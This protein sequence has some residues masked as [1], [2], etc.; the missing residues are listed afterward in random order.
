MTSLN[1]SLFGGL[2]PRMG[3]QKL[4]SA[5]AQIA[6][7]T[8]ITSGDLHGIRQPVLLK[9]LGSLGFTAQRVF[10]VLTD[11][12]Y[13]YLPFPY[14]ETHFLRAPLTVDEADRYYWTQPG[15]RP[16]YASADQIEAGDTDGYYLGVPAPTNAPTV[17]VAAG[18]TA[19]EVT[20]AYI[21]TFVSDFG[22]ESGPSEATV[23]S[24]EDDA[25]WVVSGLETSV[26]DSDQRDITRKR[27]Y[28]TVTGLSGDADYHF[29]G[30][31]ALSED[32]FYD[33]APTDE[34][35]LNDLCPSL[36]WGEP[37]EDLQGIVSHP[38]GALVGFSGKDLWFCEPYR[39]HA[40]PVGYV[41]S[42]KSNIVGLGIVG[43]SVIVATDEYPYTVT[44]IHPS[45]MS[46][47]QSKKAEPCLTINSIVSTDSGVFFASP[48]GLI[49]A[50]NNTFTNLT[51][52]L[53]TRRD[54]ASFNPKTID[55]ASY[56]NGYIAFT[57]ETDGF[58]F[59]PM[60]PLGVLFRL[61]DYWSVG[62]IQ[63]DVVPGYTH[64]V[65]NNRVYEFDPD[66]GLIVTYTWRSKEFNTTKPVNF[67]AYRIEWKSDDSISIER[68][69][70]YQEYNAARFAAGPL[71]T[72][73]Q[74]VLGGVKTYGLSVPAADPI[75]EWR[76]PLGGP[77]LY[78]IGLI[79]SIIKTV[80]LRVW[81]D[82]ALVYDQVVPTTLPMRLPAGFKADRWVFE[83]TG[84]ARVVNLK[85]A[86]T[87]T[88]LQ[89]V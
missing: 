2:A 43:T 12:G 76:Q 13:V 68:L 33:G 20:R 17:E 15:E 89:N 57:S 70:D 77:V 47:I 69:A 81:A 21:Y 34:I 31:I 80:T 73:A 72:L 8:Q 42:M 86:E 85:V 50:V 60:E 30:E 58:V 52:Q 78:P 5:S 1:I 22:E 66:S 40:W 11:T 88:E 36:D 25:D 74:H 79:D 44:G 55:G 45:S 7:N 62:G 6:E 18:G 29:A 83:L 49:M 24:G 27:I 10:R 46:P 53:A 32:T 9:D 37:P 64:I 59:S 38:S 75:P 82:D 51:Y 67:G 61:S 71:D 48:N 84:T 41:L 28:R 3:E 63:S 14:K 19:Q 35:A 26:P 39:P 56:G 23:V 4:N 65:R 87:G 54:W 16:R